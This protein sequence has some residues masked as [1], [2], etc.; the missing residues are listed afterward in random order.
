MGTIL[1]RLPT[2]EWLSMAAFK[3]H[4]NLCPLLGGNHKLVGISAD[5]DEDTVLVTLGPNIV[6]KHKLSD[7]KPLKSWSTRQSNHL[8]CQTV[9]D[10]LSEKYVGVINKKHIC[11]WGEE[12]SNLEDV[13]KQTFSTNIQSIHTL[14]GMSP[15]I[16]FENGYTENLDV[17]L[18]KRK[19]EKPALLKAGDTI[20][21]SHLE[22]IKDQSIII[23]FTSKNMVYFVRLASDG[24]P[25]GHLSIT[26][27]KDGSKILGKAIITNEQFITVIVLW[28]DG[29]L[30]QYSEQ[31]KVVDTT[32]LTG[33]SLSSPIAMVML[34]AT[35]IAVYGAD[36]SDEGA[37]LLLCDLK[38]HMNVA[39]RRLKFFCDPPLLYCTNNVL[40]LCIVQN[41][42][43]VPYILQPSVLWKLI[44]NRQTP[45]FKAKSEVS[46]NKSSMD[47]TKNPLKFR[48]A[49]IMALV[50]S[51]WEAYPSHNRLFDELVPLLKE[52]KDFDGIQLLLSCIKD[53]PEKWRADLLNF[54]LEQ[55]AEDIEENKSKLLQI[56]LSTSYSDVV[57]LNHLRR[58]LTTESTIKLLQHL[59]DLLQV[60]A[61][62][63]SDRPTISQIVDWISLVLDAHHHELLIAGNDVQVQQLIKR[64]DAIIGENYQFLDQLAQ[65]EPLLDLLK[66]SKKPPENRRKDW[67]AIEV[68]RLL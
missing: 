44:D 68:V 38:C 43:V 56:L 67:Y 48:K 28:S 8:T 2:R 16:L 49:E 15:V 45:E 23:L 11:M 64:L 7:Q 51:S 46:F 60:E 42:V 3:S 21:Q 36:E 58:K 54:C 52:D 10:T 41:L 13:K 30:V 31:G 5:K 53:L 65:S 25:E 18:Q 19:E 32:S 35:H 37:V 1:F 20:I 47:A 26:L 29:E 40:L 39:K 24:K 17:S 33:V 62:D 22:C 27:V 66:Q 57:L 12:E 63:D 34:D 55:S 14:S 59:A 6:A 61:R 9:Y 50:E 4:Y